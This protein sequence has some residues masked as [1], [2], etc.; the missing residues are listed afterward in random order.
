MTVN[1]EN[2]VFKLKNLCVENGI[3]F[4]NENNE[5]YSK[6]NGKQTVSISFQMQSDAE[7]TDVTKA[8]NETLE[9]ICEEY[10]NV[11]YTVVLDQG[12]YIELAVGSVLENLITGA[13]LA[14]LI[15]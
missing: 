15:L 5:S 6:V 4:I 12:D 11:S 13:I 10:E 7:I 8:I 2:Q 14:I 9:D 1:G 3:K